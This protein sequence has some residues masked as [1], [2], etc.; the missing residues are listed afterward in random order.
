ML[1]GYSEQKNTV[2]QLDQL[3]NT[4]LTFGIDMTFNVSCINYVYF[5]L[6]R[7]YLKIYPYA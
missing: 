1:P 4:N 2:S 3:I 7:T 5:K 6:R